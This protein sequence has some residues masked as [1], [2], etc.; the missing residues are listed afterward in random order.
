[1]EKLLNFLLKMNKREIEQNRI[2]SLEIIKRS[3]R[4]GT[5]VNSAKCWKGTSKSHWTV[6]SSIVWK[7]INEYNFEVITEAEFADSKGRADI[8]YIDNQGLPGIIEVL[9]S[10]T[11]EQFNVKLQKYPG[12]ITK[13]KTNEY[14]EDWCL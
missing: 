1:M 11:N 8:F 3:S 13:V 14:T 12:T 5:R 9:C 10:E 2:R 6:L 7:L 4:Y